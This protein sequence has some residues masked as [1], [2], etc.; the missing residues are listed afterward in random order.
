MFLS[1]R[2]AARRLA[3]AAAVSITLFSCAGEPPRAVA[4]PARPA[5]AW[6]LE[7]PAPDATYT[8]FVGYADGEGD[9]K[10]TETAS[11]TLV[12]EIVRYIGVTISAD[13]TATARSTLDSFQADLVQT[14]R[15]TSTSRVAGFQ[16]VEK[17]VAERKAG[18]VTV[19]I[20]GRYVTADLDAEK[21]RIAG[22]FQEKVDAVAIPEAEGDAFLEDGDA[23]AAARK[24]IQAAVAASGSDVE[25]ASIKFERNINKAKSAVSR[26]TLE[27]LVDR[28]ETAPGSPFASPFKAEVKSAGRPLAAV[29]ILVGYQAKLANGKMTTRTASVL[30]DAAG[31]VSF[32]HP[33]PDFVGKATL[34]MRLDLSSSTEA[35]IGLEDRHAA[36]IA[37]LEDE[38]AAKRVSFA[39]TVASAARSIPTA[40]LIGD[41]DAGG[42][43]VGTTSSA[44]LQVLARNGF[45]A[46]AAPMAAED[47]DADDTTILETAK[48]AL[49]GKAQR[50]AW[51]TTRV[52]SV[53]DDSGKKVA[54]VS[55]AIKVADLSTG[56]ILYSSVKQVPALGGTEREAADA[57][58]RALGGQI[59]GEDLAASLP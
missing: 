38:I 50:L 39:Y 21:R 42:L 31:L 5:P 45:S 13:S 34:T 44:L 15:Q 28:L 6:T 55:A 23:V 3:V 8:Y 56:R 37:G 18:G 16:I 35:F 54:T 24:F 27:K 29:P 7:T 58:R 10:A 11:A 17:Y 46:F 41:T 51:G 19:Y 2:V 32:D 43:S 9:G 36:M 59:I 1:I 12:A 33:A 30:S 47:L 22:I 57:A 26:I 52:V 20:L 40:V 14:V 4:A 25:N 53:R 48:T 49:A